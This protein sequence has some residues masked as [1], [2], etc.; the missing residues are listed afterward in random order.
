[1]EDLRSPGFERSPASIAASAQRHKSA[2]TEAERPPRR[3][4]LSFSRI[5]ARIEQVKA[6][7]AR[8][9]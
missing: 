6:E 8:E 9:A 2:A 1:M 4:R 7:E 5:L 3:R